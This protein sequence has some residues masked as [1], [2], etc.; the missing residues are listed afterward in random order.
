VISQAAA[1]NI[2]DEIIKAVGLEAALAL[3]SGGYEQYQEDPVGFGADVLGELYTEDVKRLM[4][5]VRDNPVTIAKSGN[6]LGKTHAAARVA[7][8]FY[9][10]F[11]NSQVFTA[12]APPESNLKKLLWG[13]IGGIIE[14]QKKLF[15]SDKTLSLHIERS[16]QSFL[17]GVTIPMS[18]TETQREAKFSGKHAPYLLFI[19]D[20]GDAVPDEVYRGIESCMS[21]GHARLLVMFNPRSEV[22]EAYRMERDGRAS[23]IHLSAFNHPNVVTGEDQI[24][25]AVTRETTIRR[26]NQWCRPMLEGEKTDAE[27]FEL[28]SFLVGMTAKSQSGQEYPPLKPGRY[29][30]MEPAFSYMVLG[31]YPAQGTNQLIS[32]EWIAAARSRWDLYVSR[33][34]E[35]L[36]QGVDGVAGLD[37]GEFGHDPTAMVEKYGGWVPMPIQWHGVDIIVTS[38]RARQN[39]AG[40]P[41]VCTNVDANGVGAGVAPDMMRHGFTA[42][43]VKTQ[44]SPE[45]LAPDEKELGEFKINRDYLAWRV[46][47]WLRADA[48]AMLPPDEELLEELRIPTYRIEGK[49]IRVMQKDT[50]KDLLKRSP[51]KFDALC[52][53]FSKPITS[54]ANAHITKS[55]HA[56]L[57]AKYSRFGRGM[58]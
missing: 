54:T 9:K 51:N 56:E 10:S 49:Y 21:G 25:G 35:K 42:K 41:I 57:K 27:M 52:L 48:G 13:Q 47:E 3:V 12:A 23:V 11:Q 30:V 8:W 15:D 26:I 19:I 20:E 43:A 45:E 2:A 55:Q 36:P 46:R 53:C 39:V 1:S 22:G 17:T 34:G 18:G 31:Q 24:P 29:K 50:M 40:K 38:E 5:S 14:S 7:I 44:E 33:Y 28:P 6:A 37:P 16:P 4:E 58:M 32:R